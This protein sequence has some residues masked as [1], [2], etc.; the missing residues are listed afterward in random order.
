MSA[1]VLCFGQSPPAPPSTL[2][3]GHPLTTIGKERECVRQK[4]IAPLLPLLSHHHH[5]HRHTERATHTHARARA[6]T[7][8]YT[9]TIVFTCQPRARPTPVRQRGAPHTHTHTHTYTRVR[10]PNTDALDARARAAFFP[11]LPHTATMALCALVLPLARRA[12]T[13]AHVQDCGP[14]GQ[15]S[16]VLPVAARGEKGRARGA[17]RLPPD[18]AVRGTWVTYVHATH[19]LGYNIHGGFSTE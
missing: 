18:R 11:A 6:H 19:P 9:H 12:D 10:A 16:R 4:D 5:H 15:G 13:C 17:A 3:L 1:V 2:P 8:N 14:V 7:Q